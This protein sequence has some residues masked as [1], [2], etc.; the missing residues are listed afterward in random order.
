MQQA[1][2]TRARQERVWVLGIDPAFH[3][4]AFQVDIRLFDAERLSGGHANLRTYQVNASY[5]FSDRMFNLQ[6]RVHLDEVELTVL[7]QEFER[8]SAAIADITTGFDAACPQPIPNLFGNTRRRRF[9]DDLL[10]A[11]LHRAVTLT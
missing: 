6:T 3:G 5:Q 1:D 11:A 7:V 9:F 4:V 8:A 10:M 2:V